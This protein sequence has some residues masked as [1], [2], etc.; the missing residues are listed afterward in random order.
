MLVAED[1]LTTLKHADL[2]N[3]D[4]IG[5]MDAE[6]MFG[7]QCRFQTAHGHEAEDRLGGVDKMY[8]YIVLQSLDIENVREADAEYLV[9]AL[10]EDV[11]HLIVLL[12]L[13]G[14]FWN[15]AG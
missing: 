7:W 9:I 10:D 2:V 6:E 8:L 13:W 3:V 12:S 14:D 1:Y 5:T 11:I 4:N 15:T